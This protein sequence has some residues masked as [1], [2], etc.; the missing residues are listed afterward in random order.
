[1][2]GKS[3][4]GMTLMELVFIVV[5]IGILAAVFIPAHGDYANR[6]QAMEAVTLMLE[7]KAPLAEHFADQKKWPESLGKLKLATQGRYTQS[8]V[9]SKG[10]GATGELELTATMKSEGV[11][12]RVAGQSVRLATKDGGSTWICGPG[13]MELKNLPSQCRSEAK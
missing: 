3:T 8:V 1:M 12:R 7:A 4:A 9:I 10:A 6:A 13:T 11:D 5:I 2:T